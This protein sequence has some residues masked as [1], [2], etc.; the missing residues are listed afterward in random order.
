[1]ETDG[2]T[3]DLVDLYTSVTDLM[4]IGEMEFGK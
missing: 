3:T 1:M 2:E 4:E